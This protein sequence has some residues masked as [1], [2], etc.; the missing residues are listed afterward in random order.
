MHTISLSMGRRTLWVLLLALLLFATAACSD[1]NNQAVP[2]DNEVATDGDTGPID[3]ECTLDSECIDTY[4]SGYVCFLGACVTQNSCADTSL[5]DCAFDN[6]CNA[7]EYCDDTCTCTEYVDTDGDDPSDGDGGD[8]NWDCNKQPCITISPSRLNFGAVVLNESGLQTFNI[9]NDGGDVLEIISMEFSNDTS[10]DYDWQARPQ[11]PLRLSPGESQGYSI[12]LTPTD[13][14]KDLGKVE[15]VCNDLSR[16]ANNGQPVVIL[17]SEE[18]GTSEIFVSP[19]EYDF[20]EVEVGSQ[21]I[22]LQITLKNVRPDTQDEV[23]K[24]LSILGIT[25]DPPPSQQPNFRLQEN[26]SDSIPI[27]LG[28]ENTAFFF[29]YYRPQTEGVHDVRIVITHDADTNPYSPP[30][31]NNQVYVDLEG[32]GVQPCLEVEPNPIDF[33][34]ITVGQTTSKEVALRAACGGTIEICGI[35]WQTPPDEDELKLDVRGGVASAI[36]PPNQYQTFRV[37]ASPQTLGFQQYFINICS[38]DIDEPTQK[39]PVQF[40]GVQSLIVVQPTVIDF[41]RVL[42]ES[43]DSETLTVTNM[44][45]GQLD[46]TSITVTNPTEDAQA[47]TLDPVDAQS[48]P[49][50]LDYTASETFTIR[51]T[52]RHQQE[53][54]VHEGKLTI[55][56]NNPTT[57]QYDVTVRGTAVW[58]WCQF[59]VVGDPNFVDTIDFGEVAIG[60]SKTNKLRVTNEGSYKCEVPQVKVISGT[61]EFYTVWPP[62]NT[63]IEPGDHFDFDITYEPQLYTGQHNAVLQAQTNDFR[64]DHAEADFNLHGSGVNPV[65]AVSPPTTLASPHDFGEV[66]NNTCKGPVEI[67]VQNIGFGTLVIDEI[68]IALMSVEEAWP[69]VN[70]DPPLVES[71]EI[72]PNSSQEPNKEWVFTVDFC[73]YHYLFQHKLHLWI[74]SNDPVNELTWVYFEGT[75]VPC[76]DEHYTIDPEDPCG[77]YCFRPTP[78]SQVPYE[79][80]DGY[81]N[82]CDGNTDEDFPIGVQCDGVGACGLGTYE[83]AGDRFSVRCSTDVGGSQFVY[84]EEVCDTLDNDCDGETDENFLV[85]EICVGEG[86]CGL[87]EW[88]CKTASEAYCNANDNGAA[89]DQCD[90]LDNDCDGEVDE[91]PYF[92]A[93]KGDPAPRCNDNGHCIGDLCTGQGGCGTEGFGFI[94]CASPL[95]I[96][97]KYWVQCSSDPH[98]S[99]SSNSY[100]V[101]NDQDDDCDSETDEDYFTGR[102]DQEPHLVGTQCQGQGVCGFGVW[103]C[104]PRNFLQVICSTDI[105]GSDYIFQQET[106]DGFDNDCD[107]MTDEDFS[108]YDPQGNPVSCSGTGEC[109]QGVW[110]CHPNGTTRRCSSD[111]GGSDYIYFQDFCDG[112]DNDCDGETDESYN[113]NDPCIGIGQCGSGVWECDTTT[114]VR[115][116]TNPGGSENMAE[117]ELCDNLDNN[118]NG[119]TDDFMQVGQPCEGLGECGPGI[120]EC[121]NLNEQRCSTDYSGSQYQGSP[122]ICDGLDNNCNG[123]T[124]EDYGAGQTC[125]GIGVCGEVPG[126]WECASTNSRRCSTM[127]GGSAD[128][129]SE[130]ICN[131][132]DDDCNG[133]VDETFD[134]STDPSNCGGCNIDCEAPNGV[135]DCDNGR[136]VVAGCSSGYY[137]ID[138]EADN[139]C[140][141]LVDS[142]DS[143]GV[144]NSCGNSVQ[145]N[146]PILIDNNHQYA[147]VSGNIAPLTDADWF[148]F[149]A[150]DGPESGP[151]YCDEFFVSVQFTNNPDA[152]F[153]FDIYLN[154][155]AEMVCTGETNYNFATDDKFPPVTADDKAWGRGH[156]PCKPTAQSVTGFNNCETQNLT[157][158]V[159]VYRALSAGQSPTCS[160]YELEVSNGLYSSP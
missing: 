81:D 28:P 135:P 53:L 11:L 39:I 47:F 111:P 155:C 67:R 131:E 68:G 126:E 91:D 151:N 141:C 132:K 74:H 34:K 65:I 146:P 157:F 89:D 145:T 108:I 117:P 101:C 119:L 121:K 63:G 37:E 148:Q 57:P 71:V 116:S 50:T 87:G 66:E 58:P 140:E 134:F 40:E 160:T 102:Y 129:S 31:P 92:V 45:T 112:L 75:G 125:I 35:E 27:Y 52:P 1:S 10:P 26:L 127:P 43:T 100:E 114:T 83:C 55:H 7:G 15:I 142:S 136:C 2:G 22:P 96:D 69:M 85:G 144:G 86:E 48:L 137:D 152:E 16:T 147:L 24:T 19:T 95:T 88:R 25:L 38:N 113:I 30:S 79:I 20:G 123:Q 93:Y 106:C 122:D 109:G 59:S 64:P 44:G 84:N 4:G 72:A 41:G 70:F 128:R 120:Y 5:G 56:T 130:E 103:E 78:E 115:C 60:T 143:G 61:S 9:R 105:G 8:D 14:G 42:L 154:D 82:D 21:E 12:L 150:Q 124:D 138:G 3:D 118:C 51:Y 18:K 77:Y 23:N 13:P 73:P 17:E 36:I 159:K 104:D 46:I 98:G 29:V 139:G 156:C 62:S 149:Q 90:G 32:S 99:T 33:G 6:D 133:Y 97:D 158:F 94:E 54:F 49:V 153:A 80:C 107:G 110:E 76:Q